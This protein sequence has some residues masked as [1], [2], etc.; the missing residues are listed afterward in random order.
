MLKAGVSTSRSPAGGGFSFGHRDLTALPLVADF[1]A[2]NLGAANLELFNHGTMVTGSAFS[3]NCCGPSGVVAPNRC[4]TLGVRFDTNITGHHVGQVRINSNDPNDG[5]YTFSLD[6]NAVGGATGPQF[7]LRKVIDGV[8]TGADIPNGTTIDFGDI[9]H[10]L[11][12]KRTF[13][14]RNIGDAALDVTSV[15]VSGDCYWRSMPPSQ[16]IPPGGAAWFS[17]TLYCL[18]EDLPL[19]VYTGSLTIRQSD[20]GDDPFSLNLTGEVVANPNPRLWVEQVA[21]QAPVFDN[22]TITFPSTAVG[23]PTSLRFEIENLSHNANLTI[24]NPTSLVS[25]ACFHQIDVPPDSV[26]PPRSSTFFRVR[27]HCATPGTFTGT[28]TIGS[29]D[30]SRPGPGNLGFNVVGEVVN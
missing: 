23:V 30:P 8:E 13:S 14:V 16:P 26:V 24:A 3:R 1:L 19:G 11:G 28:V 17:S 4:S 20:S 7:V 9:Y 12:S 5:T 27:L 15:A 10:T 22:A 2:C 29:N 6:G 18:D 25:G 21:A